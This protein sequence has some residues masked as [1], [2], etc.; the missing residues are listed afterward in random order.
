VGEGKKNGVARFLQVL[1]MKKKRKTHRSSRYPPGGR[2]VHIL[3]QKEY[4]IG[5]D[6]EGFKGE[7]GDRKTGGKMA[8][9]RVTSL[10]DYQRR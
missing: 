7:R 3:V 9:R 1:G 10:T 4:S 5:R 6:A 8:G 2:L